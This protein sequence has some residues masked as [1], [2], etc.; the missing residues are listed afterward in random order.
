MDP[1]C[2][3]DSLLKRNKNDPFLKRLVTGDEKWIIYNNVKRKSSWRKRNEAPLTTAKAGLHPKKVM[4]CIWWDWRGI[5][6][7][8]ATKRETQFGQ[9]L[10]PI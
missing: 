7:Y 10:R 3:S 1:I 2:I 5:L 8:F 4:L 9:I 6:H